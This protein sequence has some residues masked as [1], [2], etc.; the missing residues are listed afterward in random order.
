MNP[1][2]MGF[3]PGAEVL[4]RR[5]E[6]D[7]LQF[8]CTNTPSALESQEEDPMS[9]GDIQDKLPPSTAQLA[10]FREVEGPVSSCATPPLF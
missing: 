10:C 2:V 1:G 4:G 7:R 3:H 6:Q 5:L 8:R 9:R